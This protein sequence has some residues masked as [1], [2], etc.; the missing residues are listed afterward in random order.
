MYFQSSD[1]QR[2]QL[3]PNYP[4]SFNED[5]EF[6]HRVFNADVPDNWRLYKVG[7]EWLFGLTT[8]LPLHFYWSQLRWA[9]HE[10]GRPPVSWLELAD[11][12]A[13]THCAL[14][15]PGLSQE[16]QTA[17]QCAKFFAQASKRMGIICKS[18]LFPGASLQHVTY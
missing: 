17:G 9:T 18:K 2:E 16:N 11:F 12:H 15:M 14:A 5:A 13:A 6:P 7:S 3:F 10:P 1:G 8:F 4:W